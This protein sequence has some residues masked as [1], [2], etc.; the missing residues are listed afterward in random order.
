MRN[1]SL[2]RYETQIGTLK[3]SKNRKTL[4]LQSK[5]LKTALSRVFCGIWLALVIFCRRLPMVGRNPA[6]RFVL[7][8][9]DVDLHFKGLQKPEKAKTAV[10]K[11]KNSLIPGF[12]RYFASIGHF[13]PKTSNG[14]GKPC[15]TVRF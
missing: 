14:G 9:R 1:G 11:A 7:E 10:K 6:Q 4:K 5:G 3:A 15:A 13:L 2:R 8:V 12:L